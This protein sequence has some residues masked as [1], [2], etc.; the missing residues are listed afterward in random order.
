MNAGGWDG[1]TRA[2]GVLDRGASTRSSLSRDSGLACSRLGL[3]T[4]CGRRSFRGPACV[5]L[6][7]I[8]NRVKSYSHDSLLE[9]LSVPVH[10]NAQSNPLKISQLGELA[11]ETDLVFGAFRAH[12][13]SYAAG[14]PAD[15]QGEIGPHWTAVGLAWDGCG[16]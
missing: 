16:P 7:D 8:L 6:V 2:A 3:R 12:L 10:E 9:G 4:W 15:S 1:E 14:R 13:G 5:R 11:S